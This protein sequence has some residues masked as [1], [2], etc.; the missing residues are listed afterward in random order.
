MKI[1]QA[2]KRRFNIIQILIITL[3]FTLIAS[4]TLPTYSKASTDYSNE[5]NQ[6]ENALSLALFYNTSTG[7]VFLDE[8]IALSNYNF[9]QEEL[10]FVKAYF[11][12][13]SVN[14][15]TSLLKS[16]G[17]DVSIYQNKTKNVIVGRVAPIIIWAGVAI[18]GILTAGAVIFTSKYFNYKE[19]QNLVNKCYNAGGTPKLDT[20]DRTGVN[21][22]VSSSSSAYAF[23]CIKK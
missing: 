19:K 16:Q 4:M 12:N 13:L 2:N 5:Y 9:E 7:K 17:L 3:I 21:G 14:D 6:K 8:S 20:R 1:N 22:K 18:V 11:N 23:E 15:T 10:D